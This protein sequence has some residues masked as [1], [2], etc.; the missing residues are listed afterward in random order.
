MLIVFGGPENTTTTKCFLLCR[1]LFLKR[2]NV[3]RISVCVVFYNV[4]FLLCFL[5]RF[6]VV[7]FLFVCLHIRGFDLLLSELSMWLWKCVFVVLVLVFLLFCV[8][9][10][11]YRLAVQTAHLPRPRETQHRAPGCDRWSRSRTR[12]PRRSMFQKCSRSGSLVPIAY[13]SVWSIFD[14]S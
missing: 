7:V 11:P 12:Q 2:L 6:D 5:F 13:D 3:A 14:R 10:R 8:F 4:T 9:G 1:F